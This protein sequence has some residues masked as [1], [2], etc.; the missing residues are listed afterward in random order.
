MIESADP[1]L[2]PR[3]VQAGINT[4][5]KLLH[6]AIDERYLPPLSPPLARK[7]SLRGIRNQGKLMSHRVPRANYTAYGLKDWPFELAYETAMYRHWCTP[8]VERGRPIKIRKGEHA[9]YMVEMVVGQVAAYAVEIHG[10]D[11]ASLTLEALCRPSLLEEY[12]WGWIKRRGLSTTTIL[13]NLAIMKTIVRYW[14]KDEPSARSIVEIIKQL[15]SEAPAQPVRNKEGR[16]LSLE[17]LHHLAQSLYPLNEMR[18]K[19]SHRLKVIARHLSNPAAYPLK[20][21]Y[22]SGIKN[23][24]S[25][26]G[27]SL[28]LQLLIHRPLRLGNIAKLEFR[29]LRPLPHAGYEIVIPKAE[30]KNGKFMGRAEWRERFPSRLLPRLQEWLTI[31]RPHLLKPGEESPYIFLNARGRPYLVTVLSNNLILMS[32]RL[33]QDRPDGAVAWFAHNIRTTWTKE[34]LHAGLNPYIVQRII[35]DSFHV[36]DKHYG[37]YQDRPPSSFAKQLAKEIEQGVD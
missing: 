24:V 1:D 10:M 29:H 21:G 4:I 23:L 25:W 15:R 5:L 8:E 12:A 2:L 17:E 26:A 3:S 33:T 11:K 20:S 18:L 30:L 27:L 34:M 16:E 13:K 36:I 28:I 32:L 9:S 22:G 35:G 7:G 19:R 14:Y 37:G 6:R 31:W